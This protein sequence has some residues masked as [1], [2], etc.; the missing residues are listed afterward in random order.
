[1]DEKYSDIS[2]IG[3]HKPGLSLKIN[4]R[5]RR[6]NNAID[7]SLFRMPTP[8]S[9]T[10]NSRH[11]QQLTHF[12]SDGFEGKEATPMGLY[13][14]LKRPGRREP[15]QKI[16]IRLGKLT[17][18]PEKPS[19]E[20]QI[21]RR[22]RPRINQ[23]RRSSNPASI[24]KDGDESAPV[25]QAEREALIQPPDDETHQ[26]DD[27]QIE[28]AQNDMLINSWQGEVE[29][30]LQVC[31][32]RYHSLMDVL[33]ERTTPRAVTSHGQMSVTPPHMTSP[34]NRKQSAVRD[35][36]TSI[37]DLQKA[38]SHPNQRTAEYVTQPGEV[39]IFQQL[40][41]ISAKKKTPI[42][43][44]TGNIE[45]AQ[46][47]MMVSVLKRP[48]DI[49]YDRDS[50]EGEGDSERESAKSYSESASED[51]DV[52]KEDDQDL[53]PE[54]GIERDEK[55][56]E[57]TQREMGCQ[58]DKH[59]RLKR[60]PVDPMRKCSESRREKECASV[61]QEVSRAA[62]AG[63]K[64]S[65]QE[66]QHAS[67][68]SGLDATKVIQQV[69]SQALQ[70]EMLNL[71]KTP[72]P[73]KVSLPD[74]LRRGMAGNDFVVSSPS[75]Q[76][77][78][79]FPALA[80]SEH[81]DSSWCP[82]VPDTSGSAIEPEEEIV[83]S[84]TPAPLQNRKDIRRRPSR[85]QSAFR[86][87]QLTIV[88]SLRNSPV[89]EKELT[90]IQDVKKSVILDDSQ[91]VIRRSQASTVPETQFS[92]KPTIPETRLSYVPQDSYIEQSMGQLSQ[93][94]QGSNLRQTKSMP[95]HVYSA[96][97]EQHGGTMMA[98]GIIMTGAFQHTAYPTKSASRMP[99]S[100]EE[101]P[102]KEKSLRT[103]TMQ[104]SLSLGTMPGSARK[105]TV[106]LQFNPPFKK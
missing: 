7:I 92:T 76:Q 72:L 95:A 69:A 84:P 101:S 43:T 63:Q 64:F 33:E 66:N 74:N 9:H 27:A 90:S 39:R 68:G 91:K 48:T 59:I 65:S 79:P 86:N 41:M 99:T 38:R 13:I 88:E 104:A 1:L 78:Q 85:R 29:A 53:T 49:S 100:L 45:V 60:S 17:I 36:T 81:P 75:T 44:R 34:L 54:E 42:H 94:I 18:V 21:E 52:S 46:Q 32:E 15:Y 50:I 71:C 40:S 2:E 57:E 106:S 73:G 4:I 58:A 47:L 24:T 20:V 30:E 37:D 16:T 23:R 12:Y 10:P 80:Q 105:R 26:L 102:S 93:L 62:D 82:R 98:G 56:D 89:P 87:Q 67:I 28:Q 51:E 5:P 103:L 22:C 19:E 97:Q 83:D 3:H 61:D 6:R 96:Q 77:N 35:A 31:G 8:Q 11:H 14:P 25:D 55:S 70:L